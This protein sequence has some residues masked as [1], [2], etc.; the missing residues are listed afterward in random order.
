MVEARIMWVL[1]IRQ[2]MDGW[3]VHGL[4]MEGWMEGWMDGQVVGR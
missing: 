1:K 3:M 4:W 2:M